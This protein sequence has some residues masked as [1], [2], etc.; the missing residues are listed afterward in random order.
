MLLSLAPSRRPAPDARLGAVQ[1]LEVLRGVGS[2]QWSMVKQVVA[3]V[4]DH[5]GRLAAVKS[6]LGKA[7]FKVTVEQEE[8]FATLGQP[9]YMVYGVR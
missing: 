5:E 2:A 6:L 4:H 7:G 3:E 1:E 9:T 8:M